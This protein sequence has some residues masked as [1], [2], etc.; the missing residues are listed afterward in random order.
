MDSKRVA[1]EWWN[2]LNEKKRKEAF[3]EIVSTFE[4]EVV[5]YIRK[6]VKKSLQKE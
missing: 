2:A 6:L 5:E 4:V 3:I 1:E